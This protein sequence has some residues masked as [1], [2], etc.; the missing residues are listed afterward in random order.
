MLSPLPEATPQDSRLV[1]DRYCPKGKS[2]GNYV[3]YGDEQTFLYTVKCYFLRGFIHQNY[4]L[5]EG[6][7]IVDKYNR[8]DSDGNRLTIAYLDQYDLVVILFTSRS[9]PPTLKA[10]AAD[11]VKNRLRVGRPTWVFSRE[12]SID[13]TKEFS[14][15]LSTF[16]T[17]F[18][19]V[20]SNPA[21][22]YSGF[23]KEMSEKMKLQ[24]T[25]DLQA[26]LGRN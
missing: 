8:P 9:E 13:K 15:E 24:K 3:F 19:Y 20:E 6:V 18:E 25:Q 26:D 7:N 21:T 14:E 23:S 17:S 2:K 5:L 16:L 1:Y 12:K 4:E 10:C 11:V 22:D